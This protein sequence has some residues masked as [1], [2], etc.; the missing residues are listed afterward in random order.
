M[1]S[2]TYRQAIAAYLQQAARP[3]DK[4]SHQPRLYTTAKHLAEAEPYDDDVV[5]AAAWLHDLGVFI[6]HRPEDP[7]ALAQWDHLAYA[8][9]R[10]PALLHE[11]GFP[12]AK[13]PAVVEVIRTHLPRSHPTS[14][15]GHLIHDA[16]I[17]EQLGAVGVMRQL[18]KVGRDSRYRTHGPAI[19]VLRR[20]LTELF[21]CLTLATARAASQERLQTLDTFLTALD[22]E[23][24]G[25]PL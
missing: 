8:C 15:E 14:F 17:L 16:D 5:Y 23:T 21:D 3:I 10:V 19:A 25:V 7:Q 11:F 6:G 18:S 20:N 4:F 9:D 24:Q 1:P 13:I 2:P 12:A 22:R